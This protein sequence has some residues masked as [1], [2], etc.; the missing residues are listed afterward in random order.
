ML[1]MKHLTHIILYL[2]AVNTFAQQKPD[3]RNDYYD[4]KR[5][6]QESIPKVSGAIIML[7]NSLTE[8]GLWWEYFP[9]KKIL[10]RGIGGDILC[11]MIDRLPDILQNKPSKMFITAGINDILFH[12]ITKEEFKIR[13]DT[14]INSIVREQPCCRIYLESLLPVNDTINTSSSFLKNK[15]GTIKEFNE[16]IKDIAK[17]HQLKYIDIHSSL[18]DDGYLNADYTADGIH[19]NEKGYL[20]WATLLKPYIN[21]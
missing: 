5:A 14:I 4:N 6:Q 8:R 7:G 9:E 3:F 21:E 17:K 20:I 11:G 19:L 10:N 18:L 2:I 13:Y 1:I 16:L 12:N 15:N